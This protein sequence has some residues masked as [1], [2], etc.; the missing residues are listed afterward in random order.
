MINELYWISIM[1]CNCYIDIIHVVWSLLQ[2]ALL[3]KFAKEGDV[4]GVR[5]SLN[6]Q[7]NINITNVVYTMLIQF[8]KLDC[9]IV[10]YFRADF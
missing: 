4:E 10:I 5:E 9:H 1:L 8:N 2:D 6:K 3:L 7:A